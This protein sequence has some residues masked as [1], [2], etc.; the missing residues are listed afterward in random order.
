MGMF[1]STKLAIDLGTANTVIIASGKGIVLNE[2]TVAAIST[3]EHKIIAVGKEAKEMLGKVPEGLEAR[4]PLQYGGISNYLVAEALLK[5]L[6]SKVIPRV[7]LSRPEV[8]VSVPVGVTSVEERAVIK[9]MQ[10]AGAGKIFLFPEPVAAAI[11]GKLPVHTP[12]GNM[13]VNL[14]GGTAEIAVVS[15]NGVVCHSSQRGAGDALTESIARELR[16]KFN[17][18]VGEQMAERVKMQVASATHMDIPLNM[19][20]RG[21]NIH[22]GMPDVVEVDSNDLVESV[23]E[24][25]APIM[26]VIVEVLSRTP[27][28]LGADIVDR[29][30]VLS[31]GTAMLRNLDEFITRSVRVPAYVVED[32]LYCVVK[33][34]EQVLEHS[35]LYQ[36]TRVGKIGL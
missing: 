32:P 20:V 3:R 23:R 4:R 34:L 18:E 8:V 2:P 5:K 22:T 29:G 12:A 1:A 31:G 24:V 7:Q 36:Q 17:L 30:I 35:D 9:V 26:T 19:Q 28:E 13:I 16:R 6:L 11:G 14:G 25:L 33:G 15:L 27:P 21:R 10:A